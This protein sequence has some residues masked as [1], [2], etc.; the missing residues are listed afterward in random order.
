MQG[1]DDVG[2]AR[3]QSHFFRQGAFPE[4]Y[5]L[6]MFNWQGAFPGSETDVRKIN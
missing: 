1:P 4:I 5:K 2:G 6:A 3:F